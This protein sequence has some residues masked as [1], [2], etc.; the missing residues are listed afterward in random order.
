MLKFEGDKMDTA[1][2]VID[3]EIMMFL[4]ALIVEQRNTLIQ[5]TNPDLLL[6]TKNALAESRVLHIR[7][8][9]EVFLSGGRG[10]DIKAN[11]IMPEW[12]EQNKNILSKLNEAYISELSEIGGNPKT[13]IDKHLAHATLK[14]GQSFDWVPVIKRMEQPLINLLKTLPVEKFPSLALLTEAKA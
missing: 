1:S 10:D 12:C 8:L 6:Y 13:L 14:R 2:T 3:Y 11:N 4:R 9:A 5:A 7:V